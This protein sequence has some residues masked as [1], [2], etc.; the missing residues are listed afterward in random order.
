MYLL[1][2][3]LCRL[4]DADCGATDPL[5]V[6]MSEDPL[7]CLLDVQQNQSLGLA[8]M[9][10]NPASLHVLEHPL[11]LTD[12]VRSLLAVLAPWLVQQQPFLLVG[13]LLQYARPFAYSK[14]SNS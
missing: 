11:M 3:L 7:A 12:Q 2:S 6:E 8:D 10:Y 1:C 5:F 9:G 4:L 14:D 13:P